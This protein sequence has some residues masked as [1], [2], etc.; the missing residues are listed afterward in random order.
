VRDDLLRGDAARMADKMRAAGSHVW[1]HMWK[2]WHELVRVIPEAKAAI[3]RI[4]EFMQ[5]KPQ[6]AGAALQ[7]HDWSDCCLSAGA[8][9]RA[10]SG[11][12]RLPYRA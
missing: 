12:A 7:S 8:A 9:A 4:A 2:V 5:D 6:G 1:P 3:A 11:A 10:T